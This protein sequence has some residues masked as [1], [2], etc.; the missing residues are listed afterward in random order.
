MK[1]DRASLMRKPQ[2]RAD[3]SA[4]LAWILSQSDNAS[5]DVLMPPVEASKLASV[6]HGDD[7]VV[8][9]FDYRRSSQVRR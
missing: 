4:F 1:R 7:R 3:A 9:W 2:I 8:G 5:K 6:V